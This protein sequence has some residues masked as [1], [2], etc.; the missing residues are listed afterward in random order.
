ME[1]CC[2]YYYCYCYSILNAAV[3]SAI[4]Q[5]IFLT[6]I[7]TSPNYFSGSPISYGITQ[8]RKIISIVLKRNLAFY[9]KL[10]KTLSNQHHFSQI[11]LYSS[12]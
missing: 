4:E 1:N 9:R 10:I 12:I 5:A 2:C 3:S 6:V 7:A 8:P 11:H